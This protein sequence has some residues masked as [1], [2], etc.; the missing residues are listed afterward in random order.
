M[1]PTV[2]AAA[3]GVG[4]TV[5]VGVAGFFATVRATG[6]TIQ[7]DRESRIWDKRAELYVDVIAAMRHRQIRRDR[8]MATSRGDEGP[9]RPLRGYQA[10]GA[11]PDWSDIDHR[12]LAYGSQPV[13]TAVLLGSRLDMDAMN[14]F[15][16]WL[17]ADA[18][19]AADNEARGQ[20]F[21]A[22]ATTP[23]ADANIARRSVQ[24]RTA[25]DDADS[26]VLEIIR[27]ELQGR[28]DPLVKT[29]NARA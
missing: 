1:D 8:S 15:E 26:A 18:K 24:A 12:L 27:A 19:T 7:A 16:D 21:P 20:V 25:A 10:A 22:P 13:I 14:A 3:I 23:G 6:K 17:A 2:M 29:P 4:G 11:E 5:I 28:T 9:D